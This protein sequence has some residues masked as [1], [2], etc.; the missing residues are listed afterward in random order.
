M[1]IS[2]EDLIEYEISKASNIHLKLLKNEYFL[3]R[4]IN[5]CKK[6]YMHYLES[7]MFSKQEEAIKEV[8]QLINQ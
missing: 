8:I 3:N 4:F 1:I 6:R 7:K 5:K 2:L